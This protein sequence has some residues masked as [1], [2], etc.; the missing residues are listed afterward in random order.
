MDGWGKSSHIYG[1][2][3]YLNTIRSVPKHF[4]TLNFR[5][6]QTSVS[7]YG[8]YT[9]MLRTVYHTSLPPGAASEISLNRAIKTP[10]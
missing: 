5:D 1:R 9:R 10:H 4:D 8:R 6:K 7:Y 2:Y 3:L